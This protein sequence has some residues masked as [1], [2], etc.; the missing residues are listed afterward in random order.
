MPLSGIQ[1][2]ITPVA[3]NY[4]LASGHMTQSTAKEAEML[5][6]TLAVVAQQIGAQGGT[7]SSFFRD[8]HAHRFSVSKM[9]LLPE[10]QKLDKDQR[11]KTNNFIRGLIVTKPESSN[12]ASD[13]PKDQ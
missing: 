8:L 12:D 6:R 10:A 9:L 1:A 2:P 5:P 13:K 3:A 7:T 4:E 11:R